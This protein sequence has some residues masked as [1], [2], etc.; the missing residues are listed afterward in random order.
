[1]VRVVVAALALPVVVAVVWNGAPS[2]LLAI[3]FLVGLA[4]TGAPLLRGESSLRCPHCRKR[5]KLGATVCHHC[6]RSAAR[7]TGGF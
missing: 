3:L 7:P 2:W 1:M 6:G 5:V 4:A